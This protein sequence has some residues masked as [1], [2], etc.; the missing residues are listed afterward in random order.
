[1]NPLCSILIISYNTREMTLACV[2][3]VFEQAETDA[4]EVIVLDNASNDGSDEALADEF[5]DRIRLI[6][7]SENV[8]FA[9]G[10]N[11]AA[12]HA[13]GE[14]LL[15][16][17]PDTVVLDHAIDRLLDFANAHP[18]ARIW[19]CRTVY[20]DGSL[21]PGS[22]W[23]RQTLWSLLSRVVGLT[24]LFPRSRVLNPE[25]IGGWDRR[26]TRSVDI[27]TG[28]CLLIKAEFWN[29]LGGF[30]L[31]YFMYGEEADLC[32]RARRLGANP[33]ITPTAQIVHHGGA[34]E[35]VRADK[36]KRLLAAKAL[37]IRHHFRP[38]HRS[39][40]LVLLACWPLSRW[41]AHR[42]AAFARPSS[43]LSAQVWR[44]VWVSRRTW[45]RG[46]FERA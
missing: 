7:S 6:E 12:R 24:T 18:D 39:L 40:G 27:V 34:S 13:R 30:N 22:C 3:S 25:A 11:E 35:T 1:M 29:A 31:D 15:L 26:D 20:A 36:L 28:C 21:N 45:I 37:L 41:L 32:Y 33:M 42:V 23:G 4:F 8:G 46:A 9:G 5:G 10:N 2:R 19:G 14:Y 43:K 44:T 38:A 17:N 16:L